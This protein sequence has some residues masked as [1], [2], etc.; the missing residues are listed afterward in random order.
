MAREGRA[1]DRIDV[2][3]VVIGFVGLGSLVL[4]MAGLIATLQD[5]TVSRSNEV[6]DVLQGVGIPVEVAIITGLF[7]P[8]VTAAVMGTLV[9]LRR[10]RDVLAMV[11]ALMLITLTSYSTRGMTALLTLTPELAPVIHGAAIIAFSSF[12]Y[13]L[14]VFPRERFGSRAAVVLWAGATLFVASRPQAAQLLVVRN[15]SSETATVDRI[16]LAGYAVLFLVMVAAQIVRFTR[17]TGEARLQMKWVMLPLA[18]IG[19]YVAVT[20]MIPSV[21]FELSP[22]WFGLAMIGAIPLSIAFPVCIARGVLKYRLYEIDVV[23]HRTLVYGALS[24]ILA[25]LY[26]G[27]VFTLQALLAPFTAESDLAVAGSTLAVAALFR[28]VR[29]RVQKLIDKSFYRSKFN[30][31]ETLERFSVD[32]RDEVDLASVSDRLEDAVHETMHPAHVSLWL[33]GGA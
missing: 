7:V 33:R 24:A 32:I 25:G 27:L 9:F 10:P 11:F 18:M 19:G 28:P 16:Y 21:F 8:M 4:G 20:V 14:L 2:L 15:V 26:V 3:R 30:A 22:T 6:T 12:F 1:I 17:A 29:G 23:I 31:E 5:P 13:F